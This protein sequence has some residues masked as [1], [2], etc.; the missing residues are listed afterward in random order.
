MWHRHLVI[1]DVHL[2]FHGT[3]HPEW[4]DSVGLWFHRFV[5][6]IMTLGMEW[7]KNQNRQ[8]TGWLFIFTTC[9]HCVVVRDDGAER[10]RLKIDFIEFY[11]HDIFTIFGVF[12]R[13][14]CD[15]HFNEAVYLRNKSSTHASRRYFHS[16]LP[17]QQS[18]STEWTHLERSVSH[19][20]HTTK[21]NRICQ[22]WRL[23]SIERWVS[24]F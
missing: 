6:D 10:R 4:C 19:M 18:N 23:I 7:N 16:F 24:L 21:W 2:I 11:W 17:S 9:V 12:D 5:Y 20:C 15:A 13:Y 3:R 1:L 22:S 8:L 14:L